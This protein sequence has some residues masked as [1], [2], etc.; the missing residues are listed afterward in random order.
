MK[1]LTIRLSE[2]DYTRLNSAATADR[3]PMSTFLLRLFDRHMDAVAPKPATKPQHHKTKVDLAIEQYET[4]MQSNDFTMANR[5]AVNA[6]LEERKRLVV[7]AGNNATQFPVPAEVKIRILELNTQ[8]LEANG[9]AAVNAN[10]IAANRRQLA[11]LKGEL[12]QDT[13]DTQRYRDSEYATWEL[14]AL[15]DEAFKFALIDDPTPPDLTH[16]L[17]QRELEALS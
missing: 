16:W 5:H 6:F 3:T 7:M 1:T 12:P 4:L 8:D 2:S 11:Q 9:G 17:A 15:Q 14:G 10:T 13:E